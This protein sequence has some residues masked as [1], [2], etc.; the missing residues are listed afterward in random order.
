MTIINTLSGPIVGFHDTFPTFQSPSFDMQSNNGQQGQELPVSKWLGIPYAQATRWRRPCAVPAWT[1]PL[2]CTQFGP[3]FPQP[4]TIVDFLF[5]GKKG[6]VKRPCFESEELGFNLNVFSPSNLENASQLPVLVWIYGGS[7]EGGSSDITLYDP[8]EWIRREA[9]SGRNFIVVTGNYRCG[10]W[11]FMACQDLVETDPE[12]LAGNYGVYDCIAMLEWVQDNIKN[13]GGDPDNVTVFGESAG[14]FI[15]GA[16]L[17]TQ[18][19]LFKRAILQSGAPECLTHRHVNS[20][21]N[22]AYF[23]SLSEYFQLSKGL[24]SQRRIQY[25][26]NLPTSTIMEFILARGSVINDYG[27]AI[28]NSR[29]EI[30]IWP[31]P[32]IQ[33]IKEGK[34]NPHLESILMAHTRDEGSI[35]AFCFQTLSVQGYETV[36]KRCPCTDRAKIDALYPSS[37][38]TLQPAADVDWKNCAGS[39]LVAD[40]VVESPIESLALAFEGVKH[41]QN[42]NTCKIFLCEL[43]ETIPAIDQGFDW[44]AFHTVDIPLIFNVKTLWEEESDQAKTS[45][46]IGRLWVNFSHTGCPDPMWPEYSAARAPMK[47]FIEKGGITHFKNVNEIRSDLEKQR[48]QFWIDELPKIVTPC[49]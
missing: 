46:T 38:D 21:L 24:T 32:I 22:K 26:K 23:Q 15:V 19:K 8:T 27:L 40:Q 4:T 42:G 2:E 13:F 48:I 17:V 49:E 37:S 44:G 16:L 35:F 41:D 39:R 45:E 25:L 7:L 6:Y 11:G 3:R 14:A 28:E 29:L 10:I 12:G 9:R 1:A 34:W 31:K 36:L 20:S 5:N 33:L 30:S 43:N 47:C 18:K